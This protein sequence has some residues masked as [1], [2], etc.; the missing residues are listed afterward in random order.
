[1]TTQQALKSAV[2]SAFVQA[3]Q[4]QMKKSMHWLK[5]LKH[6]KANDQIGTLYT[7]DNKNLKPS[8]QLRSEH[9]ILQIIGLE[10]FLF[11]F[12]NLYIILLTYYKK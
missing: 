10:G 11:I 12:K 3:G 9:I 7:K 6:G 1:M 4:V 5:I 2:K 8:E